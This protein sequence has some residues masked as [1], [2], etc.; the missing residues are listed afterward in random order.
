MYSH[1]LYD[2]MELSNN[3]SNSDSKGPAQQAPIGPGNPSGPADMK[4]Y[5]NNPGANLPGSGK[6]G[7]SN[8]NSNSN[9]NSQSGINDMKSYVNNPG[10]NPPGT[11]K[12]K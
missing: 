9:S 8:N 5:S 2:S 7:N 4:S 3:S 12:G 11:G 1:N 10:A 6:S